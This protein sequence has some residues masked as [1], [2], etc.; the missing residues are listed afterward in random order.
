VVSDQPGLAGVIERTVAKRNVTV[1][2]TSIAG[3]VDASDE[4]RPHAVVLD[5]PHAAHHALATLVDLRLPRPGLPALVLAHD[6]DGLEGLFA[7]EVLMKP[8]ALDALRQA[9]ERLIG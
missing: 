6:A 4:T 7:I 8:F 1:T 2:G 9:L 3:A 5:L